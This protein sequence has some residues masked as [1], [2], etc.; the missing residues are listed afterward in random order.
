MLD[1]IAVAVLVVVALLWIPYIMRTTKFGAPFVPTE[2]DVVQRVLDLAEVGAG[3]VFYDLGSG[4][5]RLVI[6]AALHGAQAFGIEID[7][8]RAWYS[9]VWIALLRLGK[10]ARIM[11]TNFFDIDLSDAT[12]VCLYLLQETNE[13]IQEKLEEELRPGTRVVS[14]AFTFPGWEPVAVDPEGTVYGPIYLY[15]R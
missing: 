14:V 10:N 1:F 3:D 4:D 6:G 8:L 12:V 7:R 5:G 11:Q 9:K 13:K 2:P 15:K